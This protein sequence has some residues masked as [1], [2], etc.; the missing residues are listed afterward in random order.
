MPSDWTLST[1]PI[2]AV[3]AHSA[4][5]IVGPFF[6]R[7][8]ENA[9]AERNGA[10]SMALQKSEHLGTDQVVGANIRDFRQPLLQFANAL[11]VTMDDADN[12]FGGS[13]I[14]WTVEGNCSHGI[15]VEPAPRLLTEPLARRST[16]HDGSWS[17]RAEEGKASA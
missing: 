11:A 1:S 16:S 9:I 8:A 12:N 2:W 4:H 15:A 7:T 10:N 3:W 14:V 5:R 17:F 13:E 6:M